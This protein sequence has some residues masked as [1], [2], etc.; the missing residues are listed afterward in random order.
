MVRPR[1]QR[2]PAARDASCV[3]LAEVVRPLPPG[4]AA[5][6]FRGEHPGPWP[7]DTANGPSTLIV[8]PDMNR[9]C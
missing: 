7:R 2:S 9:A 3:G 1:E 6:R 5:P 8:H 4:L